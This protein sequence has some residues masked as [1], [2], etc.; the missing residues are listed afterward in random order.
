MP[1]AEL[2]QKQYEPLSSMVYASPLVKHCAEQSA[3]EDTEPL[4]EC[5]EVSRVRQP[6]NEKPPSC[7]V[8]GGGGAGAPVLKSAPTKIKVPA[9]VRDTCAAARVC[10]FG[11]FARDAAG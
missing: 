4:Y 8:A 1:P 6:T 9:A 7:G 2:A 3:S 11:V 10:A 5:R